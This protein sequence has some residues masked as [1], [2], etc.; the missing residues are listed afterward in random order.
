MAS[1]R[2]TVIAVRR[3]RCQLDGKRPTLTSARRFRYS[4]G[5]AVFA[6]PSDHVGFS[7]TVAICFKNCGKNFHEF[8]QP[9][10]RIVSFSQACW[11]SPKSGRASNSANPASGG[12]LWKNGS[13]RI[14]GAP[15]RLG[16]CPSRKPSPIAG[17]YCRPGCSSAARRWRRLMAD[18][19]NRPGARPHSDDPQ[20]QGFRRPRD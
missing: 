20:R 17:R 4:P 15:L 13:N 6:F 5:A 3:N 16:C 9:T 2:K 19:G 11:P 10:P 1:P 8:C 12:Q 18:R 7:L 14:C